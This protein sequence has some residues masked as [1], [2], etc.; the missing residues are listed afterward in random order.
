MS[1]RINDQAPNFQA[2][3]THGRIDFHEW[4]GD[5]WAVLFSHPKDFTPVCTTELGYMASIQAEFDKRDTKL[6]GLSIDP[7]NDHEK[8]LKDV[9][10]VGGSSVRYPVIADT[11]LHVAKLYNMFPADETGSAEGRTA[12]TNATVRSVFII[13]PD[14]NIK[15]MMTYPMTTGRNFNE[16][17]RV[18]DSMQLTA[19]HKVATPVN[20]QQGDDVIIVP[21]ISNEEAQKIYPQ[22]WETVKPYLRKVKQ[23]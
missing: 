11:D 13:G 19:K 6:I 21:S 8:W 17:L 12:L 9:E 4:I 7:L 3:T 1:L 20:W 2:E 10:D 18:I 23:P 15:L 22:G 14:K 16:I 5:K